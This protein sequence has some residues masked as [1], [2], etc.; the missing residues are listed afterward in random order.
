MKGKKLI[1]IMAIFILLFSI[2]AA[3]ALEEDNNLTLTHTSDTNIQTVDNTKD[4]VDS[5]DS[6]TTDMPEIVSDSSNNQNL[7]L[8]KAESNDILGAT[9]YNVDDY[10]ITTLEDLRTFVSSLSGPSNIF[11]QGKTF[12]GDITRTIV[13]DQEVHFY[14]GSSISDPTRAT[15]DLSKF[16]LAGDFMFVSNTVGSLN[17]INFVNANRTNDNSSFINKSFVG[18]SIVLLGN[19]YN[20]YVINYTVNNCSFLNNSLDAEPGRGTNILKFTIDGDNCAVNNCEFYNNRLGYAVH[21][22]TKNNRQSDN[23]PFTAN[24][25]IFVNNTSNIGLERDATGKGLCFKIW[26]GV[27]NAYFI[28]NTFINNTNAIH[29]AAYCLFA[30]NVY[31]INNYLENNQA[32]YAGG[33]EA[34]NGYIYVYNSTFINNVASGDDHP[35]ADAGRYSSGGAI[36]FKGGNNLVDNCTFIDNTAE[37]YAGAIS[38]I[39]ANT[40]V[41]NS[42]FINSSAQKLY[43]GAIHISGDRTIIEN[44]NFEN[45]S[46]PMSGAIRLDGN[47]VRIL[48]SNFTHNI[49]ILGGACF[50]EGYN[51]YIFNS[52]FINNLASHDLPSQVVDNVSLITSGGGI[53]I[54]GDGTNIVESHFKYNSAKGIHPDDGFGGAAYIDGK[55]IIFTNDLFENNDAIHGGGVFVDGDTITVQGLNLIHNEAVQGGSVYIKGNGITII[56]T[57]SENNSAIQG[58]AFYIEG[59]NTV[60]INSKFNGNNATRKVDVNTNGTT[61]LNVMGGAIAI[62]GSYVEITFNNFT[63]NT[64]QG[65][66]TTDGLGGAISIEGHN[67][68]IDTNVVNNNQAVS[69]GAIYI[70]GP[71]AL[72]ANISFITNYAIRGGGVFVNGLNTN[73][74][75]V[76]FMYNNATHDLSFDIS[77][78]IK[79][80][81]STGG[82][83]TIH[84]NNTVLDNVTFTNNTAIGIHI[85]GGLGG[86]IAVNGFNTTIVDVDFTFNEAVRGGA[87]YINGT[88]NLINQSAFMFNNAVRGGALYILQLNSTIDGVEFRNNSATHNLR[89]NLVPEV[90]SLIAAGGAV[91][92]NGDVVNVINSKFY[93]NTAQGAHEN[94]GLGGAIAVN[95]SNNYIYNSIFQDNQGVHGGSF[96]LEGNNVLISQSNFTNNYAAQGGVGYIVG[97][98]SNITKSNFHDNAATHYLRFALIEHVPTAGGVLYILGSNVDVESSKFTNNYADYGDNLT[99]GGGAFYIDGI[100]AIIKDSSFDN[101]TAVK[102]GAV[103]I[104]GNAT[105]VY[106]SNFTNNNAV[107]DT[108]LGGD[109]GA[110]Y[111]EKSFDSDFTRCIFINNTAAINGGAINWFEDASNGHVTDCIFINNTANANGGAVFWY[112]LDGS[113]KGSNFT[114]NIAKGTAAGRLGF[115]GTGGAIFW[116]GSSGTLDTCNLFNNT[117]MAYG[118]GVY[119]GGL[120]AESIIRNSNF[121][122]NFAKYNGGAIDCNASKLFLDNSIFDANYAQY[123]AALCREVNA[124]GGYGTNNLFI[125]NHAFVAGAAL[126]WLACENITIT[127]YTFIN[128]TADYTG[129]AI[130]V[131]PNS[132]NC[133]VIDSYFEDSFAGTDGGAIFWDSGA[134]DGEIIGSTFVNNTASINGGAVNWYENASKGHVTNCSFV[135]NTAGANGGAVYWYGLDGIIKGSNFTGNTVKANVTD[136]LGF[137]GTGGA[138][139]WVGSSGTLDTC[140]LLNNTALSDGGGVYFGG[141][142]AE[143]IVKDCN[144]TNNYAK[145]NGGAIDCNAS[146]LFLDNSIFDANYAQ[147]GAALCREVNALGG[148]GANNLFINNHAFISGAALGWLGAENITIRHYTFI[149]NTADYTGGAIYVSP[150]SHNCT[151]IDS[152]FENSVAGTNGGA[153]CWDTGAH[154]GA[155]INSTFVNNTAHRAGGAV[156][157]NGK[158]GTV[159]GSNFTNNRA[160]GKNSTTLA[161]VEYGGD[162]GAIVWLGPIGLVDNSIFINNSA[163]KRGGAVYL[164]ASHLGTSENTSFTNCQFINNTAGINGGAIDWHEGAVNGKIENSS[165]VNNTAGANG[166]AVLWRGVN[167]IIINSN[168]TNNKAIGNTTG[169]YGNSGDGGAVMWTGSNGFV[170]NCTFENNYAANNGGAVHIHNITA[171]GSSHID[172]VNSKFV[173]NTAAANGGAVY[174]HEDSSYGK[175]INSTFDN[176]TAGVDGGAIYWCGHY[177]SVEGSNFTNNTANYGGAIYWSGTYGNITDSRFINNNATDGGAVFL[178]KCVH[179]NDIKITVDGSYFEQNTASRDGGAINWN[180]GSNVKVTSSQFANNTANRGGALFIN[181]TNGLIKTA[182]FTANEAIH[183]GA[184]YLNNEGLTLTESNF[185]ENAAIQ[186]GAIYVGAEKDIIANSS[187]NNNNAT[188]NLRVNTTNNKNKTKGGAIYVAGENTLVDNSEFVN[189][190]ALT[191]RAY[192]EMGNDGSKSNDGFGG[193]IFVDSNNVNITSSDFNDNKACNGSAL[194]NNASN[195]LLK[196]DSFVKNQAWSYTLKANA[197][198][199]STYYGSTISI[200][201]S[202]YT[203]GDNIINGIYNAKSVNDIRFNNVNYIIND[204]ESIVGHTTEEYPENGAKNSDNGAKL[205]QDSLERYQVITVEVINNKT[206]EIVLVKT[207]KTDIYGNHTFNITTRFAPGNYTI[208]AYHEEDRNYK[209]I[210][211]LSNFEILPYV[212]VNITKTVNTNITV[213]GDNITFTIVVSNAANGT[214]ATNLTIKDIISNTF[215]YVSHNVTVGSFNKTTLV[216]NIPA[217]ANGTSAILT[218]TLNASKVGIYNNTVN[219]TCKEAEWNYTNNNASV[220][221]E[222][223]P[224]NLTITKI[225]NVTGNITVWDDVTFIINVTNN[226]RGNATNIVVTDLIPNTFKF[227]KT[228]AT[229]Y[230]STTGILNIARLNSNQSYVFTLTLK[231]M[232]NGTLVNVV[233]VTCRQNNTA[234]KANA[235]VNVNPLVNLTVVKLVDS[236]DVTIG[237]MITFTI[238]I[239]NNGPSNAT[240]INVTDIPVSNSNF[241]WIM[242]DLTRTIAFLESG[243]STNFTIIF[244]ATKGGN[245]TNTVNVTC[246]ENQTVKSA[247]STVFVYDPDLKITKTANISDVPI[248]GLL[249]FTIYVF[250][251]GVSNATGINITDVLGDYFEF[252]SANGTYTYNATSRTIVWNVGKLSN[253]TGVTVWLVVKALTNGTF[254][255]T[256]FT[257]CNEELTKK[258]GTAQV[259]VYPVVNLTVTKK[260]NVTEVSL[261]H[262]VEFTINVTN[263]GPSNATFINVTDILPKGFKFISSNSSAYNSTSGLLRIPLLKGNESFVFTIKVQAIAPGNWT[264]VVNVT[265]GENT[266][267]VGG[268][269]SVDIIPANL[270]IEKIANVTVVGDNSLVNFTIIVNNT[271]RFYA[272]NVT[273]KD[274]LPAGLVYVSA[275][276][277]GKLENGVVTW[278]IPSLANGTS[279]KLWVVVRTNG[280]GN[281]TNVVNLTSFENA[282][283]NGNET[284]SVVPVNLTI[285]KTVNQS[286]IVVGNLLNFTI[287]VTNNGIAN[288]TDVMIKDILDTSIFEVIDYNGTVTQVGGKLTWIIP[289]LNVNKSVKVWLRVKLLIN[290]TFTNVASVNCT[291]NSTDVVS[292]EVSFRVR[293][294]GMAVVKTADEDIVYSGNQTSFTITVTNN[295]DDNLTGIFIEENIPGG[296]IYDHFI[297]A[298]WTNN[299]NK[300]SYNGSLAVGK[301]VKLVIFVNTTRSGNFTNVI[302]AGSHET[303]NISTNATLRVY[304]PSLKV[305]E[306]SNNPTAVVGQMVSFTVVVTNTGDCNLSDIYVSNKFPDGLIYSHFTG[307][308]W[309]Q[310]STGLLGSTKRSALSAQDGWIKIDEK[311]IYS[312]IL[313]PGESIDY[314]IYFKTTKAGAFT[315]E[316]IAGS[317]LTSNSTKDAYSNNTTVVL[318]PEIEVSKVSNKNTVKVGDLITFTITVINKGQCDVGD[319]FVLEKIPSGLKYIK[320]IGK[321]WTKVGNK[322]KYSNS[323]APGEVAVLKII[324]KATK[325]GEITNVVVVGTNVTGKVSAESNVVKLVNNTAPTPSPDSKPTTAKHEKVNEPATMKETGNPIFMLILVILAIIPIFRRKH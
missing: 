202:N 157:W 84:G 314:T 173:N 120:A 136:R 269:S 15:F 70:N 181:G 48:D 258:Y 57:N 176:N 110:V 52:T 76:L 111:L 86:A 42:K 205:Y 43:A 288:A 302:T 109:G 189:N 141:L 88:L 56:Q 319:I 179:E 310:E 255:N 68:T 137:N 270:T 304:T 193:A 182:N 18:K 2:Q 122:N 1:V 284:I 93:N 5:V 119:F 209:G 108:R 283:V 213:I 177:G 287:T 240:N 207:V 174:W 276:D 254:N 99:M 35:T 233:N 128:N 163:P 12:T 75:N 253:E 317:D 215:G 160:T 298:N 78:E 59:D 138:I 267:V 19:D 318:A 279:K 222:V 126:G 51:S 158:N 322:F 95:G 214:N 234:V 162:G 295:G 264:N 256:A 146:K 115:N 180:D 220:F 53:Y 297:G 79:A 201:V 37:R 167:G 132:H 87:I 20:Y 243:K 14:G 315:P 30:R 221:F 102:G 268:N 303:K 139:F 116:I 46:A 299:G 199:N 185:T 31:I 293:N 11:L 21:V 172:F 194:Y 27:N 32:I 266:T 183:G 134:H 91:A 166:G 244:R 175:V 130:Y 257:S 83:V 63:Y 39:G 131:S 165:F 186:G 97:D 260:A 312:G 24:N 147:Y 144:F 218:L 9:D 82:A 16:K 245:Y 8:N 212:D 170:G 90:Y 153:I 106:D 107:N 3:T 49:A 38:I 242:G 10:G 4:L 23:K 265:C 285:N 232:T 28:N 149:N 151:V 127:N 40:V 104:L 161:G 248:N 275:S 62:E 229:G 320:F 47:Y 227:V 210:V 117:A 224:I 17:G 278:N 187:F 296:L 272:T 286:V 13:V 33:I 22:Y 178:T 171:G 145:Y 148:H 169:Y 321:G 156:F 313:K 225:A 216:W 238:I 135:N 208:K 300:F 226:A 98:N 280:V 192:N 65:T 325:A 129:G 41:R 235:S 250:N 262:N 274:V 188:Y 45:N 61:G 154:D 155:I 305:R 140:N 203:G 80:F 96:Y 307:K 29:G 114:N 100:D 142:A 66:I 261:G 159:I 6:K 54:K 294:L 112:G 306:I 26:S 150:N 289:T 105:K 60:V 197:T 241:E 206:G 301:S 67:V 195:L 113:I 198:P 273:I 249:N 323:L 196:D 125:N 143:S 259:N 311:F 200:I 152:Y 239:T 64:A 123:G 271:G 223:V 89:F 121:T 211:T 72:I 164:E 101:N 247:N 74:Q 77:D 50:I 230:N 184:V 309:I 263:Y 55:N 103:F 292:N 204:T 124:V 228:N 85:F 316:V 71:H 290:G 94:G 246:K 236:D 58:G 277:N 219:V 69:G 191:N 133:T 7:S 34:H 308:Q 251:H 324:F 190:T 168:F 25:N 237:D 81:T 281:W 44:C 231:A 73:I 282:T 217:L 291:Q 36:G 118:G 92:I 252:V